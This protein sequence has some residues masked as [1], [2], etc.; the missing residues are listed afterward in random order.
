MIYRFM[1][2]GY[3]DDVHSV[4][5]TGDERY[6]VALTYKDNMVFMYVESNEE[7]VNPDILVSGKLIHYPDGK[8]WERASEIFHYSV[9]VSAEQWRRKLSDKKVT[10]MFTHLKPEKIASYIFYHFQGQEERLITDQRYGMIFIFYNMLIFYNESP[11]EEETEFIPGILNTKNSP[12]EQWGKLMNEHFVN[13]WQ[14]IEM[15]KKGV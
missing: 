3:S 11:Q 9:P 2:V 6:Y 12:M 14:K 15:S 13:P 1:F 8:R 7:T 4:K 5:C 10:C